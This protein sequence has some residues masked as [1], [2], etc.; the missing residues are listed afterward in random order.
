MINAKQALNKTVFKT[1]K[2]ISMAALINLE[3]K[4][5][6][7]AGDGKTEAFFSIFERPYMTFTRDE[8]D[9]FGV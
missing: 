7:A 2:D 3:S 8:I 5:I 9:L 1:E 6:L 4:V